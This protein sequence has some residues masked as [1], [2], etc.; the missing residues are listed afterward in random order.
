M[1]IPLS[2]SRHLAISSVEVTSPDGLRAGER[3]EQ[4]FALQNRLKGDSA[5]DCNSRIFSVSGVGSETSKPLSAKERMDLAQGWAC[6]ND[7]RI[8]KSTPSF[9][10]ATSRHG[11]VP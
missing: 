6:G 1:W 8:G 5:L 9:L 11:G 4:D 2:A 3:E 10:P 7:H